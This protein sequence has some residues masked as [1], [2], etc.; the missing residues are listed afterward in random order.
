MA[1]PDQSAPSASF[2]QTSRG[3]VPGVEVVGDIDVA[4]SAAFR[5][6]LLEALDRGAGS[7]VVDFAALD[8][9]DSSGLG[10][11]VGVAKRA[12]E[13]GGTVRIEHAAPSAHKVLSI[14]GLL[15]LFEI[16]DEPSA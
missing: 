11:L 7:V 8:F 1:R 5:A 13:R 10:V 4:T 14:T 2:T 12:Q 3:D 15:E 16:D 6:A 9:I